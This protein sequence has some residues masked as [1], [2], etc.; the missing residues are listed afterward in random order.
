MMHQQASE[1]ATAS[2]AVEALLAAYSPEARPRPPGLALVLE[3]MPDALEQ[4]DV[5]G[6]LLGYGRL[7]TYAGTICV[8]MPLRAGVNLGFARGVE[9]PDAEGRL[10]GTGERARHVRLSTA[11]AVRRPALRALLEAATVA[12]SR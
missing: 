9:L 3:V 8:I 1:S 5:P 4:V 6:K 12:G 11:E 2:S 7:A 10:T